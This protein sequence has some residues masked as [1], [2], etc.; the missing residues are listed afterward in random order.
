[1]ASSSKYRIR[2]RSTNPL[3]QSNYKL[4]TLRLLIYSRDKA[5]P[6]PPE[7]ICM[8]DNIKLKT[9]GGTIWTWS[10]KFKMEDSTKRQTFVWPQKNVTYK[11]IISDSSGC[12]QADTAYKQIFVRPFP[13]AILAFSDTALCENSSINIPVRFE[14]GDSNYSW[15]WYFVNSPKSYFP[16]NG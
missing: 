10:P 1:V 9:H 7:T 13:V 3:V 4:D 11:I 16:I 15:Q 6:G 14:G 8:G 5:D 2:I 12:G